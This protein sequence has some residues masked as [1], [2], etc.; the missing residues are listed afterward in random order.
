[1]F[2]SETDCFWIRFANL[3]FA[4]SSRF[5]PFIPFIDWLGLKSYVAEK[6]RGSLYMYPSMPLTLFYDPIGP[7]FHQAL[8][9]Y[10]VLVF[11]GTERKKFFTWVLGN[12]D[13]FF[14]V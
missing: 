1:M 3:F 6:E 11:T 7:S 4:Q 13:P 5:F 12:T 14:I 10:I 8:E 9:F 2:G